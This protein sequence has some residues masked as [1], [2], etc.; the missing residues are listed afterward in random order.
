M[1]DT[2]LE[3]GYNNR[4]HESLAC[5]HLELLEL[6]FSLRLHSCSDVL[7]S[8]RAAYVVVFLVASGA[9]MQHVQ[10]VCRHC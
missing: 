6:T 4:I 9:P 1:A 2:D 10:G 8:V 3:T 7:V 5:R